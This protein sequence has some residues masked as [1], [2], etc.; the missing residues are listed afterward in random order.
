M[1][2]FVAGAIR[3]NVA[4]CKKKA[5]EPYLIDG[6]EA[7]LS[8][9]IW[10]KEAKNDQYLIYLKNAI[11]QI[12]HQ[13][14]RTN[15]VLVYLFTDEFPIGT[16]LYLKGTIKVFQQ[17]PNEGGYDEKSYYAG[18]NI[19][20]AF[21]ADRV[22]GCT[23]RKK[24]WKES[25]YHLQKRL[26]ESICINTEETDGAILA[27]M[28]LGEKSMLDSE[29]KKQYR[30]AGISHILVIS[31]LHIS[32]LGMGL[33]RFLRKCKRSTGC[34][35]VISMTAIL[36]YGCMVGSG[37][38][39]VRAIV[40]FGVA[41]GGRV[42]GRAYDRA[43]SLAVAVFVML[44]QNPFLVA[45]AGFRFSVAAVIGVIA[46]QV[47]ETDDGKTKSWRMN[48]FIWLMTL[49]L[50]VYYYYE[51]SVYSL[52][53]NLMVLPLVAPIVGMG[54]MG[55]VLGL[56]LGWVARVVFFVPHILLG[57]IAFF[58]E[59]TERLPYAHLITGR[60]E[61]WK[62]LNYYLILIIIVLRK[63]KTK[64]EDKTEKGKRIFVDLK[65][66][67][68]KALRNAAF[69]IILCFGL[70]FRVRERTEIDILDV[71]Q[72]DGIC[73]RTRSGTTMFIDGGSSDV[74]HV[75]SYRIEPYLKYHGVGRVDEWFVSHGDG[76]H[77]SGLLELLESD[78]DISN[79]ILGASVEQNDN[80]KKLLLL[81][82]Q[83]GTRVWYWEKG[84]QL[85]LRE[86]SMTC[87]FPGQNDVA[88]DSNGNSLVLLYE[89]GDFQAL[90][91]GDTTEKQ[92][93]KM[94]AAKKTPQVEL[95]KAAHHGS[96]S[97]NTEAW[98]SYLTPQVSV[99]SCGEK[100]RYGHPAEKAVSHM[101]EAGSH[102]YVTKDTGEIMVT[103]AGKEMEVRKYRNLLE[104]VCYPVLQ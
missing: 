79:I 77:I 29:T 35:A 92:E 23:G 100:N 69:I 24:G 40:M 88:G 22:I 80:V 64:A 41:M 55:A 34:C 73:I 81:A 51:I 103:V 14:Y 21:T 82:R 43:T 52:L 53:V 96:D 93:E 101:E 60:P 78:Y 33:Y 3:G 5:Y 28:V 58:C 36:A 99:I 102:V 48:G 89:E 91:T 26:K 8:G 83:A 85:R 27:V 63:V 50:M 66:I 86:S 13:T 70:I 98:L 75:G 59:M 56:A 32:M 15:P 68:C 95:Y 46:A 11:L 7:E 67:F 4:E 45:D 25:L 90:F 37:A 57:V 97:S 38:S 1:A 12:N 2:A 17:A 16:T 31:G 9:V 87:I 61:E 19:D 74:R 72:G 39:T 54:L 30:Q 65:I 62:I 47:Y 6:L 76:D 71:G 42:I 49:P 18:R 10:K 20:Y 94:L 84:N 44:W 104:A